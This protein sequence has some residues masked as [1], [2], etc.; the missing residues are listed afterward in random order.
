MSSVIGDLS[1]RLSLNNPTLPENTDGHPVSYTTLRDTIRLRERLL[2]NLGLVSRKSVLAFM[3]GLGTRGIVNPD[4]V[5]TWSQIRNSV[6]HGEMVEPWSSEDGDG[7][8]RELLKLV[9]D[10]TPAHIARS[11]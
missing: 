5:Q 1:I 7:K 8:L 3:R 6:M 4:H 11:N 2:N 9:H 10:L